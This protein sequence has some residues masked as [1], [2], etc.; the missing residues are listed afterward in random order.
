MNGGV[1][2]RSSVGLVV[3]LSL[4]IAATIDVFPS[5]ARGSGAT[6]AKFLHGITSPDAELDASS[7]SCDV[8]PPRYG[9]YF[10]RSSLDRPDAV[11]GHQ[12]HVLYVVPADSCDER[13]DSS[14]ALH[15]SL[16]SIN[17]WLRTNYSV[18]WRLDVYGT[19]VRFLDVSYVASSLGGSQWIGV[20]A[21]RSNLEALGF[22][23]TKKHYLAV[24]SG[25]YGATACGEA[26]TFHS[27]ANRFAGVWLLTS[28]CHGDEYASGPNSPSWVEVTNL[29]ELVHTT[30]QVNADAVHHCNESNH[31]VCTAL[32]PSTLDPE[33]PDV[34]WPG[35]SPGPLPSR[36]LDISQDDYFKH[37]FLHADLAD[38][39]YMIRLGCPQCVQSGQGT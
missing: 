12:I 16:T 6:V 11:S 2:L 17:E 8:E 39:P 29:H 23:A 28:G 35:L 19:S 3:A 14:G 31:H 7:G 22:S 38:S 32:Y 24:I 36:V 18:R 15:D 1:R 13:L 27:Q 10:S 25:S 37:P 33:A 4:G 26:E 21:V 9:S 5:P 20:G 34:M 30:G